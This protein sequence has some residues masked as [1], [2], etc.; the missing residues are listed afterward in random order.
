MYHLESVADLTNLFSSIEN[1]VLKHIHEND[2]F[3]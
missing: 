1:Q 3:R 2:K